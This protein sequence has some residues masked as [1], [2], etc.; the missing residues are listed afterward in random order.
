METDHKP[1][2]KS[3]VYYAF[4]FLFLLSHPSKYRQLRDINIYLSQKNRCHQVLYY[5][6]SI[7]ST[8]NY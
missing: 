3:V 2:H 5:N 6:D 1:H 7:F 4:L 8:H